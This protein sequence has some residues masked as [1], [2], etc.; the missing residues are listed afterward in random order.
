MIRLSFHWDQPLSQIICIDC[1][2]AADED[3]ISPCWLTL[4]P[5]QVTWGPAADI[6]CENH[7]FCWWLSSWRNKK[8]AAR[9][10]TTQ[11][12][13]YHQNGTPLGMGEGLHKSCGV[14]GH[15]Q[16]CNDIFY[17]LAKVQIMGIMEA[18]LSLD[19]NFITRNTGQKYALTTYGWISK[20]VG[21]NDM[22]IVFQTEFSNAFSIKEMLEFCTKFH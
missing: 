2:T 4:W 21:L 10:I 12:V 14:S 11:I 1:A 17:R 7:R 8:Q 3:Y 22:A 19:L 6:T 15:V 9:V 5:H 16:L 18:G 13:R 20:F